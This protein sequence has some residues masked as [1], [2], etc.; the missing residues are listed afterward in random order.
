MGKLDFST[1]FSDHYF[2]LLVTG[3]LVTLLLF[4]LAWC[5]AM[6]LGLLLAVTRMLPFQLGRQAVDML[7]NRIRHRFTDARSIVLPCE[8]I[9]RQSCSSPRAE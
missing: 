7:T 4:A 5:L 6:A 8:I 9:L 2:P 1:L 3:L